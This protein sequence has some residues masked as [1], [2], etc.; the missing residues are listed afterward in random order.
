LLYGSQGGTQ[1]KVLEVLKNNKTKAIAMVSH[2]EP[3]VLLMNLQP[4]KDPKIS[5]NRHLVFLTS[6]EINEITAERDNNLEHAYVFA[7][8][9]SA[10]RAKEPNAPSIL[11]TMYAPSEHS[12]GFSKWLHGITGRRVSLELKKKKCTATGIMEYTIYESIL[13]ALADIFQAK[14]I[15]DP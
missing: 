10:P 12:F 11:T 1:P 5:G 2:G 7:C 9:S 6:D 15:F 3:G 14:L 4:D 13:V 8:F